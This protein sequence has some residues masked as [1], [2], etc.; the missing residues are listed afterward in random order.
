MTTLWK[1]FKVELWLKPNESIHKLRGATWTLYIFNGHID[2]APFSWGC[3]AFGCPPSFKINVVERIAK[4]RT[5]PSLGLEGIWMTIEPSAPYSIH[6]WK[7][8]KKFQMG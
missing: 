1:D 7:C 8:D 6:S 3:L 5:L 4:F 2:F